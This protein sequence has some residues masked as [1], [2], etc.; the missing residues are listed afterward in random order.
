V[1]AAS[2][3]DFEAGAWYLRESPGEGAFTGEGDTRTLYIDYIVAKGIMSGYADGSGRFGVNDLMTRGQLVTMLYRATT[4]ET[5][6]TTNNSVR[7][8]FADTSAGMYYSTAVEWASRNNIVTGYNDGSNRF[9]PDDPVTR[10]QMATI[11]YRYAAFCG[12][13]MTPAASLTGY[14]DWRAVSTWARCA[15]S[16]CVAIRA[17]GYGGAT[18][19]PRDGTPRIQAAKVVAVILHDIVNAE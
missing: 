13:D 5:A 6:Q 12:A 11:V 19:N 9:G 17:M 3:T 7:P 16:Y 2:F 15:L 4:G 14:S 8:R 18:L 10:E 1:T